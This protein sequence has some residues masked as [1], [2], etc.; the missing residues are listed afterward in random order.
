[1]NSYE[2]RFLD[3]AFEE[4]KKSLD[5]NEIPVGAV[6]VKDGVIISKGHNLKEKNNTVLD[7]AELVAI[8][9][10]SK[11][12]NNWRLND[13]DIYVTLEPCEMCAAAIKQAR[14]CNIFCALSND[15]ENTH[16]N[17]I[18]IL[19]KDKSNSEVKLFN[20]LNPE[21]EKRLLNIFFTDK[22]NK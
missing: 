22:R 10:A 19:N 12:L 18:H 2:K 13:C 9:K 20:N 11:K 8:N 5:L 15:D 4:A 14:F 6:I 3:I 17:V 7:H 16:N 21:A 1:M